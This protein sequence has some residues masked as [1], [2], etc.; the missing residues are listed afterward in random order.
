MGRF[1][2]D[3]MVVDTLGS[4]ASPPWGKLIFL[5]GFPGAIGPLPAVL[6]A[7]NNGY[8]V[9]APQ[10]PGT[11]DSDGEHSLTATAKA[12][13]LLFDKLEG[14][15]FDDIRIIAHSFGAFHLINALRERPHLNIKKVLLL[16]PILTYKTSPDAGIRERLLPHLREVVESRPRTYRIS[17]MH[18]WKAAANGEDLFV[19]ACNWTGDVYIGYGA[20]DDTFKTDIFKNNSVQTMEDRL[21]TVNV[22]VECIENAGHGMHELLPHLSFLAEF[23]DKQK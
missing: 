15:G 10:Y 5:N 12:I 3:G 16:A 17:S 18:E 19:R 1:K 6:S 13:G 2:I 8:E 22:K 11:Y 23:Y 21:G 14:E 9:L 7:L 20:E 4:G